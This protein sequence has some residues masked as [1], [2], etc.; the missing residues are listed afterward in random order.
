MLNATKPSGM[1][2][3]M[4]ANIGK[5]LLEAGKIRAEDADSILS[6]Q[7]EQGVRFGEAAIK[8]GLVT[9]ADIRQVISLQFDYPCLPAGSDAVSP[10]V[11]AAFRP[12]DPEV[13]ALRGLRSQISLRWYAEHK[14]MM[15][16]SPSAGQGVSHLVANLAVVLSQLGMRTLLID[17]DLRRPRQHELFRLRSSPGLSDILAGRADSKIIQRIEGLSNLSILVA[18][19][20]PP[21]PLELLA[22]PQLEALLAEMEGQFDNIIIDSS[23]ALECSD[24][25]TLSARVGGAMI[26]ARRNHTKVADLEKVKQQLIVA[27]AEVV[28]AVLTDF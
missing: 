19:T 2:S 26:V 23:P 4:Q 16:T 8:L 12:H 18:G 13:E 7:K 10:E 5:L 17:A 27:G 14:F 1:T 25:Q 22:R 3:N 11:I 20:V 15:V 6:V 9:E 21:N 28:G 24:A